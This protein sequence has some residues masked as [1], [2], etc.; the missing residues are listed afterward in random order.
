MP[1]AMRS[2]MML[3]PACSYR[4]PA[5]RVQVNACAVQL[6]Q[7]RDEILKA[8]AEA[9]DPRCRDAVKLASRNGTAQAIEPGRS[10]RRLALPPASRAA[11]PPPLAPGVGSRPS[12]LPCSR[13]DTGRRSFTRQVSTDDANPPSTPRSQ[14]LI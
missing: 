7:E 14:F 2:W 3:R 13:G 9:V 6:V 8:A 4:H 12:A 11:L 1:A 5:D 10:S